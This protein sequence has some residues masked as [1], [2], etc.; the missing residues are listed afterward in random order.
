MSSTTVS[1]SPGIT[2]LSRRER[3][4]QVLPESG[5]RVDPGKAA[6]LRVR[7]PAAQSSFGGHRTTYGPLGPTRQSGRWPRRHG[8]HGGSAIGSGGA[9]AVVSGR[10]AVLVHG[11]ERKDGRRRR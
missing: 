11:R 10:V 3:L 4:G 7:L 1:D 2:G 5:E 8:T 6:Q 9:T